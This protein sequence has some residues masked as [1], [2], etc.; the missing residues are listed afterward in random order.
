MAHDDAVAGAICDA[1]VAI[2]APFYDFAGTVYGRV[3]GAGA[4]QFSVGFLTKFYCTVEGL[5]VI[6]RKYGA[7]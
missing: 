1:E 6:T 4:L 2:G 7:N 5:T 3:C